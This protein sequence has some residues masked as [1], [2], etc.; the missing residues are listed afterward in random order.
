MPS[1]SLSLMA[2]LRRS[3]VVSHIE[4]GYFLVLLSRKLKLSVEQ[5]YFYLSGEQKGLEHSLSENLKAMLD[6]DVI[7]TGEIGLLD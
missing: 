4:K 5:S 3:R 2:H 1:L 6:L 7:V